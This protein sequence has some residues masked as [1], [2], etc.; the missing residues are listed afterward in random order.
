MSELIA[1][2]SELSHQFTEIPWAEKINMIESLWT[3][4]TNKEEVAEM[5]SYNQI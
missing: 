4:T 1:G 3:C 2:G 5:S